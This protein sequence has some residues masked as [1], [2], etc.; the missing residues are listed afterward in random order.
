MRKLSSSDRTA[1]IKL[2]SRL[3]SGSSERK[4]ILAGLRVGSTLDNPLE[5]ASMFLNFIAFGVPNKKPNASGIVSPRQFKTIANHIQAMI[6]E[7]CV[8]TDKNIKD[9]A[10]MEDSYFQP[11]KSYR[12]LNQYLEPIV[13]SLSGGM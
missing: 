1:L 7:G 13:D 3:P 9:M 8:F 5:I 6:D 2:A 12:K 4:A 11:F 10:E